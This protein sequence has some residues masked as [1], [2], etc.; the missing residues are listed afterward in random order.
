MKITL[1]KKFLIS[2]LIIYFVLL[3]QNLPRG[4][5]EDEGAHAMDSFF[6]Y[7]FFKDFIR[8]PNIIFNL[9][10]YVYRFYVYYPALYI[11]Y[12][13]PLFG[14]LSAFLFFIF[15][16]NLFVTRLVSMI[17]SILCL[18][19]LYYLGKELYNRKVAIFSVVTLA[20]APYFFIYSR[21]AMLDV[22]LLFFILLSILLFYKAVEKNK[23]KYFYYLGVVMG[24]GFL[25][26]YTIVLL[27]VPFLVYLIYKKNLKKN[28]N[29]LII[30][31]FLFLLISAPYL[32][33]LFFFQ[34]S[35]SIIYVL[36]VGEKG[37]NFLGHLSFYPIIIFYEMCPLVFLIP[38]LYL[39][40]KRKLKKESKFLFLII[41]SF[42]VTLVIMPNKTPKYIIPVIP[43]FSLLFVNSLIKRKSLFLAIFSIVLIYQFT[44][45][46]LPVHYTIGNED[47]LAID[48]GPVSK[49]INKNIINEGNVFLMPITNE[50]GLVFDFVRINNFKNHLLRWRYCIFDEMTIE[51]IGDYINKNNIYYV[52]INPN[53]DRYSSFKDWLDNNFQ[54]VFSQQDIEI[55]KNE[56][57]QFDKL[58]KIC[59]YN[60]K[61]RK[62][63][64]YHYD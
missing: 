19:C 56:K 51:Q 27:G 17:F 32:I 16:V 44:I 38:F 10:N 50:L 14:V 36:D 20:F 23:R 55:Y 40:K 4:A 1:I 57:K 64:C 42:F 13:P 11:I 12:Y 45:S 35:E 7:T 58:T 15:G 33:V 22:P 30:A 46:M 48:T 62:E 8:N 5:A 25:I 52:V 60:C 63:I 21:L 6:Y 49:Y 61:I 39:F 29:P 43:L 3:I 53:D 41:I 28:L 31:S 9:E 59:D 24:I 47:S 26:K 18:I 34:G 2:F 54:K 37:F